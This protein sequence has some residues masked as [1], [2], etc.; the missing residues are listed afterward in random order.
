MTTKFRR[1]IEAS[2]KSDSIKRDI[3]RLFAMKGNSSISDISKE[4]NLSVPTITKFIMELIEEGYVLDFGK[5]DT[6]G[7]RKPN[8]YG[9]NPDA[10]FFIGVNIK[11][12][13]IRN[14]GD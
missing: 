1:I 9:L 13:L 12:T 8:I 6:S 14:R 11:K 7:G 10:G 4:M 2:T 3:L 5:Q